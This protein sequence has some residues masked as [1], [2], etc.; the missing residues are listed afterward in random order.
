[1]TNKVKAKPGDIV[2]WMKIAPFGP[3]VE[4][5]MVD[6]VLSDCVC[7]DYLEVYERRL[8]NGIPIDEFESETRYK[9]L[10][11]GWTYSTALFEISYAPL[12]EEYKK[13]FAP[14]K[15]IPDLIKQAYKDGY[16]IKRYQKF[17]GEITADI[18]KDGYRIIKRTPVW[19]MS[20]NHK[21]LATTVLHGKYY[22]NYEEAADECLA[23]RA[24]LKRQSELSDE[25]WSKE[26]IMKDLKL[27]QRIYGH[28]DE[29]VEHI[30]NTLC[31]FKDVEDIET[32]V[33]DGYI[34]WKYWKNKKWHNIE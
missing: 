12:K 24:E 18:T 6:E 15:T 1:M 8:V 23:Y 28:T 26:Q 11:K 5:G 34:Q 4:W 13:Y 27:W 32:R 10:P 19:Y 3:T 33:F 21:P 9:K 29:E 31:G 22:L 2:Y 30:Y 17:Q 7:V 25:E 14:I 20:S 16:L